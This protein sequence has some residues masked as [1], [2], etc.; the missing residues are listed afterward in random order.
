MNDSGHF[1][2]SSLESALQA[3]WDGPRSRTP[4]PFEQ[5]AEHFCD[6]PCSCRAFLP[7]D[8]DVAGAIVMSRTVPFHP[9]HARAIE[10]RILRVRGA[11][12]AHSVLAGWDL[13]ELVLPGAPLAFPWPRSLGDRPLGDHMRTLASRRSG[14]D[15]GLI[16]I[17]LPDRDC[18]RHARAPK[19]RG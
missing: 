19:E 1:T 6:E 17:H 10:S 15:A 5:I 4:H 16:S 18:V 9:D 7:S 8:P 3:M 13:V 2:R 12:C 14:H 11:Y